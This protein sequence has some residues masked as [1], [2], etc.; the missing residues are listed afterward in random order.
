M[1]LPVRD[2]EIA[3]AVRK[4]STQETSNQTTSN[5]SSPVQ[6]KNFPEKEDSHGRRILN[7]YILTTDDILSFNYSIQSAAL[8]KANNR[9]NRLKLAE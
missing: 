6:N 4:I 2:A 8:G 3:S 1:K 9:I 7:V 5:A